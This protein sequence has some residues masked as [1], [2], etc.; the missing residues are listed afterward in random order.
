MLSLFY[1]F[2]LEIDKSLSIRN[3]SPKYEIWLKFYIS[4]RQ[5]MTNWL[6]FFLAFYILVGQPALLGWMLNN[7]GLYKLAWLNA[8][9]FFISWIISALCK[10]SKSN[11]EDS[12][13]KLVETSEKKISRIEN[14]DGV[15]VAV[16]NKKEVVLKNLDNENQANLTEWLV[17]NI[18][19]SMGDEAD[20]KADK[21]MRESVSI[22]KIVQPISWHQTSTKKKSKELKR[23]QRLILLITLGVVAL[24]AWT[25]EEFLWCRWFSIALFLGWML[26]LVTGKLFDVNGFYN[27]KKLVTNRIY[28]ILILAWIGY[29]VYSTQNNNNSILPP[30][31][32]EKVSSYVNGLFKS[33]DSEDEK[34]D[35]VFEW[36]GEVIQDTWLED[37][38]TIENESWNLVDTAWVV[39]TNSWIAE[40]VGSESV[41]QPEVAVQEEKVSQTEVEEQQALAPTVD[42][43]EREATWWEAIKHLLQWYKLSTKTDKSF[44]Y[45]A[46]SNELYPYFKTA[47][48]K[49]MIW[50]D[51]NPNKRISCE[52]YMSLKWILEWWSVNIYDRSQTRVIYWNKAN[53]LGKTNWCGR[54]GFV[55]VKNL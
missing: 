38:W 55:K 11:V 46:K 19:E 32:S 23:W 33:D 15:V 53:E 3:I 21:P 17:K 24:V 39:E 31:F 18:E 29:G 27:A 42:D 1:L 41:V 47:Q 52:T 12:T 51:V 4:Y 54:W 37:T 10:S 35:Y 40:N 5:N 2:W 34:L 13:P 26:Y 9:V 14:D 30:D 48:E 8:W 43:P 25:L 28:I 45:V 49:A 50:T 36:T 16:E 7:S 22:P 20:E 6:K 44:T